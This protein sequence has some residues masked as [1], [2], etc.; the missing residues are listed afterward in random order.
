MRL[1]I[2]FFLLAGCVS[3]NTK[4]NDLPTNTVSDKEFLIET[5]VQPTK[6][7]RI[8]GRIFSLK[9]DCGG[10]AN[11]PEN[12]NIQ[13]VKSPMKNHVFYLNLDD[14]RSD[15]K[16]AIKFETDNDG[17]FN[18]QLKSGEYCLLIDEHLD[19]PNY[20]PKLYVH[21][22]EYRCDI[23]CY[24]EWWREG[25]QTF[26]VTDSALKMEDIVLSFPCEVE[27]PCPCISKWTA[28]TRP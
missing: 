25:L 19:S 20:K 5:K 4:T 8:T 7:N 22:S 1:F 21:H 2:L 12:S 15:R 17:R 14:K 28:Q 3:N 24:K 9:L 26:T 27:V 6:K 10:G 16:H 11:I 13:P 23:P 18:L